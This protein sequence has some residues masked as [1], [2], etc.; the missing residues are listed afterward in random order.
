MFVTVLKQLTADD[1]DVCVSSINENCC[2]NDSYYIVV[3]PF[4][5]SKHKNRISCKHGTFNK[6]KENGMSPL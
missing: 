5:T 2:D 1:P 6:Y 4:T 3:F